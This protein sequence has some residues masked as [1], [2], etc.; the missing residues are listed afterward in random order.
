MARGYPARSRSQTLQ[1][2]LIPCA[3]FEALDAHCQAQRERGI[4]SNK[5]TINDN[6]NNDAEDAGDPQGESALLETRIRETTVEMFKRVLLFSQG[7]AEALYD[8]QM[9]TTLDILQ[10]LTNDIIKVLCHAI[11]KPGGDVTGQQFSKLSVT[12]LKL[13]CLL[14]KAHV[15]DFKQS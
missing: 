13:F 5:L 4:D 9:I 15:A 2:R 14:G 1:K 7:A 12:C 11:R 10:N 6:D 8:D 3:Q